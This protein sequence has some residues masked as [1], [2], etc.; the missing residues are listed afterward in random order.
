MEGDDNQT[1]KHVVIQF[2]KNRSRADVSLSTDHH[3]T[4]ATLLM[5]Q[6]N[7]LTGYLDGLRVAK[8]ESAALALARSKISEFDVENPDAIVVV[9]KITHVMKKTDGPL[10]EAGDV[11][12]RSD[13]VPLAGYATKKARWLVTFTA[14]T[15]SQGNLPHRV[16]KNKDSPLFEW[17]VKPEDA[18]SGVILAGSKEE[19]EAAAKEIKKTEPGWQAVISKVKGQLSTGKK[20][21]LELTPVS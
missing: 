17:A 7:N 18:S 15:D 19:A 8:T 9:A 11:S 13:G 14:E 20:R 6:P 2:R 1:Y 21:K 12:D 4:K 5:D 3:D 16:M 10:D